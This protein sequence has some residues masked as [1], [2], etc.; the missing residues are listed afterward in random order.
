[1]HATVSRLGS[2]FAIAEK[3][4]RH[5]SAIFASC[6]FE[7][8]DGDEFR[9]SVTTSGIVAVAV[10]LVTKGVDDALF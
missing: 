9:M 4:V 5:Q 8:L 6:I 7:L 10:E 2:D 3:T 1:L